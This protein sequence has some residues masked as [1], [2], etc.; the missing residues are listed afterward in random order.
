MGVDRPG[1]DLP[2]YP[3]VLP[4]SDPNLC[5]ALCNRTSECTA[6]SFGVQSSSCDP[7]P[8]CWLKNAYAGTTASTCRASGT[9]AIPAG[10]VM[11]P[12]LNG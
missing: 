2:G 8:R 4:S 9:K 10:P 12:I 7:Q 1:D 11:R 3:I 5:W 6:W